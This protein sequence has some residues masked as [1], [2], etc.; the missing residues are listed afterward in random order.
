MTDTARY[1][2]VIRPAP[3]LAYTIGEATTILLRAT[4][5]DPG[6]TYMPYVR[7]ADGRPLTDRQRLF[8]DRW[9]DQ[10]DYDALAPWE[11]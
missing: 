7:Q 5:A 2:V 9:M 6:C 8:M 4:K 11:A 3:V 1:E 10:I